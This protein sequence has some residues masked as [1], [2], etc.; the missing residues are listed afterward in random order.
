MS[1]DGERI[2]RRVVAVPQELTRSRV[3]LPACRKLL[4]PLD[5]DDEDDLY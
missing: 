4:D 3:H 5:A 1:R 2:A